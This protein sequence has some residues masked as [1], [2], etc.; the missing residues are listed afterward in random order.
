MNETFHFDMR[1]P[2]VGSAELITF[3]SSSF[4][5]SASLF[6]AVELDL[7]SRIE[8]G[9]VRLEELAGEV[10]I[11]V[12]ELDKL[13]TFCVALGLLRRDGSQFRNQDVASRLLVTSSSENIVPVVLH[14]QKH[15]Y[16]LFGRLTDALRQGSNLVKSWSFAQAIEPTEMY[17]AL[18][19][20]PDEYARFIRAMNIFSRDV[21]SSIAG[22]WRP[23]G[24]VLLVD[25]G[26][27]GGAVSAELASAL[28]NLSVIAVDKPVPLA[29]ASATALA[30]GVLERV[31]LQEG[32]IRGHVELA[33]ASA[34]A[35]L[36]SAVL[37]DWD[38]ES[39]YAILAEARRILKPGGRLIVSETLL[40][41]DGT[42]PLLPAL[43][44][45]YVLVLTH[46]GRNFTGRALRA[47]L[48]RADFVDVEIIDKKGDGLRDIALAR[49]AA[50]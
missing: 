28:P 29:V 18:E 23:S 41:N 47:L 19:Q 39:Q 42:G 25:L 3:L 6:S 35:V 20:S 27:G 12:P 10:E 31:R 11:A 34:D 26:C 1:K 50:S 16:R 24:D 9:V 48:T 14:Y 21:G 4:M 8:R 49:K 45:L 17:D 44:S 36:I 22:E 13:L 43:L 7:F 40:S 32:D 37:G 33:D 30:A 15:V 2:V 5:L 38:E 46:G